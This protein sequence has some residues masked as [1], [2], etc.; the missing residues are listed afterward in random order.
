MKRRSTARET[1]EIL[2]RGSYIRENGESVVIEDALQQSVADTRHYEPED[3]GEVIATRDRILEGAGDAEAT[4]FAVINTTTLA[5]ARTLVDKEPSRR[6]MCLNFAS[7][8]NPGGGFLGGSQAQEESL[9]RATGLYATIHGVR[10]Y[11]DTNR[12]CGTCLYT[13]HM[14]YSPDVPVF[15]DDRDGLLERTVQRVIHYVACG[16]RRGFGKLESRRSATDCSDD[17]SSHRTHPGAVDRPRAPCPC[18]G[19]VGLRSI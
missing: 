15:R 9:A 8:K 13:D 19:G 5:A 14:I 11:Y 3:F 18:L 6:V 12:E 2:E 4:R 10:E 16:K 7:A 1:V 17:A